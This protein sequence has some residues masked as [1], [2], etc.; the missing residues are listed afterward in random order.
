VTEKPSLH[1]CPT[2]SNDWFAMPGK[3]GPMNAALFNSGMSKA[4]RE[5]DSQMI[6]RLNFVLTG[7]VDQQKMDPASRVYN[8]CVMLFK[9]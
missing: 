4:V 3:I 8:G 1:S 2:E 9:K 5:A 6:F 7:R